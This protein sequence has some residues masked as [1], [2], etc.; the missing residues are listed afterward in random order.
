MKILMVTGEYPPMKGGVGRYTSNLVN[1]LKKKNDVEVFVAM[2]NHVV[3]P[4]SPS[5]DSLTGHALGNNHDS[6]NDIYYNVIRKGDQKNSDRLLELVHKLK[7]D[8]VNIQYERGL[9]E[10]DTNIQSIIK[11][12]LYGSTL[13][14]FFKKTPVPSVTTLHTV[15]PADEYKEYIKERAERKEGRFASLPGPVRFAIRKWALER[16]YKLL[17]EIVNLSHNIISPAQT[18]KDLVKTGTVIYHGAEPFP[19]LSSNYQ[20]DYRRELGLPSNKKLLLAFGYVGS[21]KG[22]DLLS[23]IEVPDGWS[24]VVKQNK[25]ERGKEKPVHV[26][27][28]VNLHL[29][30]LDDSM[31]SKLFFAC[32]AIIFPYRLVSVSGVMFDALAHGL[33]FVASNLKFFREFEEL[34]LG[35]TCHRKPEDFSKALNCLASDYETFKNKIGLF[36]SLL[37]WDTVAQAHLDF[38]K[39]QTRPIAFKQKY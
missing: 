18:L 29:G 36:G 4:G 30:Y 37:K 15:M 25:H 38:F 19:S 39:M 8:I 24:L 16:R 17:F 5:P 26:K 7:P 12:S 13:H 34:G 23:N 11:R 3:S 31:L 2:G 14:K 6:L 10:N 32:D 35:L 27:G 21:Y 33:P 1:A 28:A 22:F 20:Q 9:Y